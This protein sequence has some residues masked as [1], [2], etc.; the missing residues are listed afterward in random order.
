[1]H[2]STRT[3]CFQ[4]P[5]PWRQQKYLNFGQNFYEVPR[6]TWNVILI[7][8]GG[9]ANAD[10]LFVL[11]LPLKYNHFTKSGD[12]VSRNCCDKAYKKTTATSST[13]PLWYH[14]KAVHSITP[15]E[16][17]PS[18]QR[19]RSCSKDLSLFFWEEESARDV[20]PASRSRSPIIQ[21]NRTKSVY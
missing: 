2:G 15:V 14:L 16:K 7:R 10:S 17:R 11:P 3:P 9:L 6:K 8:S 4:P 1:M 19:N 12:N 13:Y 18:Q 21:S 5:P 20:H